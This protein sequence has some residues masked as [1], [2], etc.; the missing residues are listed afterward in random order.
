MDMSEEWRPV[1]GFPDYE[2]SSLGRVRRAVPDRLGRGAGR[3]LKAAVNGSGYLT[4][5]PHAPGEK[6]RPRLISRLVCEAFHG[7]APSAMHHAAHADG[8]RTNNRADNLRWAT[9]IEN[10]GDKRR[11]GTL[12]IGDRH[13][14]RRN[15][16]RMARGS[17]GGNAK[18][19]E[20]AV[21]AIRCDARSPR[22]IAADHGVTRALIQMIKARKV[23]R[24]VA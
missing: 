7:P 24:H 16:E 12:A 3:V 6:V 5:V 22:E 13:H 4:V 14:A 18:L 15:P 10:E 20:A 9:P 21:V 17:R 19:T 8:T 23:W 1:E 11:H 2:V